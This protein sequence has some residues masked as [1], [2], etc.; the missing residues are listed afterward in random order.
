MRFSPATLLLIMASCAALWAQSAS[1]SQISGTVQDSTGL[2][3]PGAQITVT[4]TDT[5]LARATMSG[6]DGAYILPGLPVGPYRLE[7]KKEGFSSYVQSGIVLQVNTNPAI[8]ITLTVGS[9]SEQVQVE[10][11]A[12]MVE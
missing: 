6:P 3:V 11:G 7:A 10:A 12:A 2:V 9:V 4:Q 8:D 1:V 5:G